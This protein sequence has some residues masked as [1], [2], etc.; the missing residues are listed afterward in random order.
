MPHPIALRQPADRRA[1]TLTEVLACQPKLQ[2]RQARGAFTLI[3]LLVVIA[4]IALLVSIL[5]PSLNR[6]KELAKAAICMSN[7]RSLGTAFH[8][9]AQEYSGY[10]P[11]DRRSQNE[12]WVV[13]HGTGTGNEWGQPTWD[14]NLY[15][16]HESMGLYGC[17]SDQLSHRAE[18]GWGA[19]TLRDGTEITKGYR[20]FSILVSSYYWGGHDISEYGIAGKDV[21]RRLE[22]IEGMDTLLIGEQHS[23]SQ[24]MGHYSYSGLVSPNKMPG[25]SDTDVAISKGMYHNG[26]INWTIVDGHAE[27]ADV[28]ETIGTG[29]VT[30]SQARGWWSIQAGD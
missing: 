4:I 11:P 27:R 13:G 28:L 18:D 2:R 25:W 16:G 30:P 6:A 9:Y 20:S 8:I 14:M 23:T 7:A 10:V 5:L 1:F 12:D 24:I 19:F 17:P 22:E 26:L 21:S 3:E 29:D 15:I